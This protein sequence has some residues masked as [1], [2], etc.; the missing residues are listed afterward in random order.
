MGKQVKVGNLAHENENE[1]AKQALVRSVKT[2]E[3][4]LLK[5]KKL[6]RLVIGSAIIMTTCP[7]KYNSLN[8]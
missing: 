4:R 7:E 2:T 1:T 5:A 6:T 8:R 3:E